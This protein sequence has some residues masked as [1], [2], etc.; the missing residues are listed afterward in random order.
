MHCA[1]INECLEGSHHCHPEAFCENAPGF[2]HC[3]CGKGTIG[4][5]YVCEQAVVL[6]DSEG[7]QVLNSIGEPIKLYPFS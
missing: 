7:L 4:D 3:S 6:H 5:G 1:D 2:Y